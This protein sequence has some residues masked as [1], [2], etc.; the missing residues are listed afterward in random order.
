MEIYQLLIPKSS[1]RYWDITCNAY[2][3]IR[4]VCPGIHLSD[5]Y[6][7]HAVPG[8]FNYR[9]NVKDP[10]AQAAGLGVPHV[11]EQNAIWGVEVP[12]S[13]FKNGI[14]GDVV[15]LMQAYWTSFIVDYDPNPG[16]FAGSPEWLQWT[17]MMNKG[18]RLLVQGG[19]NAST[20]EA[21]NP[22]QRQRCEEIAE[23][24]VGMKQ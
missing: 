10:V 17:G 9:Y 2:S 7:R 14:N 3:E 5:I 22:A 11:A 24:G 15:P 4:Y 12:A 16:K 13:Y 18:A 20:M 21:V 8:I 1:S 19:A 23:W 6:A